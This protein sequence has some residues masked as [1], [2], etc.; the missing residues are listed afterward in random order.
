[1]EPTLISWVS[2]ALL[3][4][5][6][7]VIFHHKITS[8][9][10]FN[11][12]LED[13]GSSAVRHVDEFGSE[14]D[15]LPAQFVMPHQAPSAFSIE[16]YYESE[17]LVMI[18]DSYVLYEAHTLLDNVNHHS[19]YDCYICGKNASSLNSVEAYIVPINRTFNLAQAPQKSEKYRVCRECLK[20]HHSEIL[21]RSDIPEIPSKNEK[22]AQSI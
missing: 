18:F 9:I 4:I 2:T 11:P 12:K 20:G 17:K 10:A 19:A 21:E 7:Y 22:L 8:T 5:G 3:V 13:S 1:M 15:L 6:I 14:Y 16:R